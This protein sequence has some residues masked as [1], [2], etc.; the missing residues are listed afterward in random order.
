ML[1]AFRGWGWEF[2]T[3]SMC[4]S[5]KLGNESR[6]SFVRSERVSDST[7]S[8]YRIVTCVISVDSSICTLRQSRCSQSNRARRRRSPDRGCCPCTVLTWPRQNLC[9][10]RAGHRV[11]GLSLLPPDAHRM[12]PRPPLVEERK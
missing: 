8:E 4:W 6:G 1:G 5:M 3:L 9:Q 7:F 10:C 11:A 12:A 2:G